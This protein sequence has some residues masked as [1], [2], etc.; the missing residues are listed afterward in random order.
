MIATYDPI[1][2]RLYIIGGYAR[3]GRSNNVYVLNLAEVFSWTV[4]LLTA[5]KS[6]EMWGEKHKGNPRVH[7]DETRARGSRTTI[8]HNTA[9][10]KHTSTFT[11]IVL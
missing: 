5:E 7:E 11:D 3:S 1:G 8:I 2:N 4:L 9:V 6:E 10:T